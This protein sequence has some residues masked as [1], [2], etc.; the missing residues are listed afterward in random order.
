M[1]DRLHCLDILFA[2]TTRYLV[3]PVVDSMKA[4]IEEKFMETQTLSKKL[5]EP[6]VTTTKRKEGRC[7]AVIQKAFS[8]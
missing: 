8:T 3:S 7:A 6:I 5:Y 1:G 4:A 2:F